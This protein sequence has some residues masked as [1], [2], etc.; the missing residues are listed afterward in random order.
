MSYVDKKDEEQK[1][2]EDKSQNPLK[3]IFTEDTIIESP[4]DVIEKDPDE[5]RRNAFKKAYDIIL[6]LVPETTKKKKKK[7]KK[8]TEFDKE[9]Q[10]QQN[11]TAQATQEKKEPKQEKTGRER[12]D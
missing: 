6:T 2:E 11:R 10:V 7:S 9:I 12:E 4:E 3:A 8:Q 1:L 5:S